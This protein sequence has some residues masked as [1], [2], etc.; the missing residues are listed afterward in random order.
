[1]KP[2][3]LIAAYLK[4]WSYDLTAQAL[5]R[6]LSHRFE[7][8]VIHVKDHDQVVTWKPDL[9]LDM[10]WKGTIRE[11]YGVPVLKQVSSHRWATSRYGSLTVHELASKHLFGCVGIAVP[12][13]RL[14]KE[15]AVCPRGTPPISLCK[16]GFHP[17]QLSDH[18]LRRSDYMG[19][20]WAGAE[21][22]AD[23]NVGILRRACRWVRV[24][25]RCL[26]QGEMAEFYNW[27]DLIAI[28]SNAEGDPRPL[29]EGMACGCFPITTDVGIVPE[30]VVHKKNGFIMKGTRQGI[31][32]ALSWC[33]KHLA[34]VRKA[35]A[36]NA[37][38]ML[39]TRTWAHVTPG[40]GDAIDAALQV[41]KCVNGSNGV[42]SSRSA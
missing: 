13:I 36:E 5:V 26:T 25:D 37:V 11:R 16:K 35:G 24:A 8:K 29:I 10:W 41:S 27:V 4:G 31:K 20:G 42:A 1:M 7:F 40:W 30:L 2:R 15:L 12:S 38:E 14:I 32:E 39:R 6:H 23:K 19:V 22:A 17:D 21:D 18:G 9:V 34:Q 3:V 33:K 28:S